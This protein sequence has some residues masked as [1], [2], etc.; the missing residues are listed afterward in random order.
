MIALLFA[1][2][3]A[4]DPYVLSRPGD[5]IRVTIE[6]LSA[7]YATKS[8]SNSPSIVARKS[9]DRPSV[10]AGFSVSIFADGLSNPRKL[11][12]APDGAVLVAE[13]QADR[14][15][16]LT[17]Q[18]QATRTASF[19][20]GL[21]NPFGMAFHDGQ[22]Y[23]ADT[24]G[25]WRMPYDPAARAEDRKPVMVTP[26]GAF[27]SGNGHITRSLLFSRDGAQFYVGIGSRGN[28]DE[29]EA[30]RASIQVFAADGSAQR[31]YASGLRNPIGLA[32]RPGSDELYAVVN[33]RDGLGD[34]LVP[35]YFTRIQPGGF[36]GWPYAYLGPHPQPG[37][38]ERRPDL[39]ARAI[40]PDV[41]FQ[42]HS[43]P[44]DM[45]FYEAD[46]FPP[47]YRG[48]AFVAL[49]GSWN[50]HVPS[51]YMVA[52]I[53]FE[54][55]RPVGSYRAFATGFQIGQPGDSRAWGRPAGV[56]VAADGSLLIADDVGGTIWRVIHDR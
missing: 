51:G 8:A 34:G 54:H 44:I 49:H 12:I 50:A 48:S 17:G 20:D 28:I 36:Y 41:L 6:Q 22:L 23:V 15:T 13:T 53:P 1:R 46:A 47:A 14:I 25:V 3:A 39:V 26:P 33:E 35:D 43:A 37:F 24:R 56:A 27:G 38:G 7:P 9:S 32:R 52:E 10:P 30:P 55:G 29:E 19:V 18:D 4:A 42:S 5:E 40:V 11:L 2:P 21:S 45:A 16:I 31:T